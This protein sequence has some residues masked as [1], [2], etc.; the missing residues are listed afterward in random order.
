MADIPPR[1]IGVEPGPA[2]E[3]RTVKDKAPGRHDP[4]MAESARALHARLAAR[5]FAKLGLPH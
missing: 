3:L 5:G 2:T 1:R 4:T